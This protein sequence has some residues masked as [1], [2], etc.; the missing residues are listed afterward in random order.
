MLIRGGYANGDLIRI[1]GGLREVAGGAVKVTVSGEAEDT[2]ICK[3]IVEQ[4]RKQGRSTVNSSAI[5]EL[6]MVIIDAPSL[7]V[8]VKAYW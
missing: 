5:G 4:M 2:C 6:T 7:F 1:V 8:D 3:L